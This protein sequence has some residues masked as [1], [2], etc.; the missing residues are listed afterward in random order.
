MFDVL[1]FFTHQVVM[2]LE[3]VSY[4]FLNIASPQLNTHSFSTKRI[5]LLTILF[6]I[7]RT[8]EHFAIQ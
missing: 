4:N 1:V 5:S 6:I 3:K 8:L 2:T 7:F